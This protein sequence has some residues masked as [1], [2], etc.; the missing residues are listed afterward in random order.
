MTDT[1]A[2]VGSTAVVGA[3]I[4]AGN[5]MVAACNSRI[6]TSESHGR[7]LYLSR[8]LYFV[9]SII[10]VGSGRDRGRSRDHDRG[11]GWDTSTGVTLLFFLRPVAWHHTYLWCVTTRVQYILL[12]FVSYSF[13]S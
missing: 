7:C 4:P 8:G 12:L 5:H 13:F 10:A 1:S 6:S 11:R 2:R 3:R 9:A